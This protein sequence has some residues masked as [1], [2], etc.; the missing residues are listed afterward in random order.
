MERRDAGGGV[1]DHL[2]I[3]GVATGGAFVLVKQGAD[4]LKAVFEAV[5]AW[6]RLLPEDKAP[7]QLLIKTKTGSLRIELEQEADV[8]HWL[9]QLGRV[10]GERGDRSPRPPRTVPMVS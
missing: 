5:A 3:L 9:E 1:G 8:D 2:A 4:A 7:C 6:R 10:L